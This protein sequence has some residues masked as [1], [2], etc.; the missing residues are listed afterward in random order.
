MSSPLRFQG[1]HMRQPAMAFF[2]LPL[3][4]L[5]GFG[6]YATA[7]PNTGRA[8]RFGTSSSCPSS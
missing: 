5:R 6:T 1:L 7:S 2:G 3:F 4:H 8:A